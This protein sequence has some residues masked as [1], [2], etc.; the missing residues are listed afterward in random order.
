MA[1]EFNTVL[2]QRIIDLTTTWVGPGTHLTN[3]V[4]K[5]DDHLEPFEA[6]EGPV[7][8]VAARQYGPAA[9]NSIG[10]TPDEKTWQVDLYYMAI[11]ADYTSEKKKRDYIVSKLANEFE[12]N[13]MLGALTQVSDNGFTNAVVGSSVEAVTFDVSGQDGY[14]TFVT[15]IHLTVDVSTSN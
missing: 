15:E 1:D 6:S 3:F 11:G 8:V 5:F 7:L 10:A 12:I 4:Q 9:M 13:P 2:E 14:Y